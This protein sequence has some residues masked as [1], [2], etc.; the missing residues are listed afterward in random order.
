[1]R[2][3]A[4]R[5]HGRVPDI[6]KPADTGVLGGNRTGPDASVFSRR[7]FVFS[8]YESASG[9]ASGRDITDRIGDCGCVN[10]R[11]GRVSG[12]GYDS[13]VNRNR[14]PQVLGWTKKL[15]CL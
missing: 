5:V 1:M 15:A 9:L 12:L 10:D 14:F 7:G 2:V 8:F 11:P 3:F 4:D 6:W 13:Q